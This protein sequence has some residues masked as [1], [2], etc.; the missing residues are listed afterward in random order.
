MK[1]I[2]IGTIGLLFIV[3][4][5]GCSSLTQYTVSEQAINGYLQ[6]HNNY[7]Q[8]F[9]VA[10]LV[11]A[12]VQLADLQTE[13]GQTDPGKVG[14][15][16]TAKVNMGSILGAQSGALQLALRAKPVYDHENGAIYLKEM[17]LADYKLQAG[18]MEFAMKAL[19]PYLNESL[20]LYFNQ[21]PVYVLGADNNQA[22]A[23]A[24][25]LAKRLEVQPGQLV[26]PFIN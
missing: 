23:L 19:M 25:Q 5:T 9:N 6:K 20:K 8:Q 13:I 3:L 18:S 2:T 14:V 1:K 12:N 4:L 11:D 16:G 17:E 7:Q 24:R 22:E 21:H 15:S 10:G 26:I